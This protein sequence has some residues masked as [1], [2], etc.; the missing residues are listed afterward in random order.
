MALADFDA[1]QTALSEQQSVDFTMTA[2]AML[3]T[4]MAW[5]SR[6]FSPAPA[7]PTTS[8]ALDKTSAHSMAPIPATDGGRLTVLGARFNPNGAGG[9]AVVVVDLLNISGGLSGTVTT[10]QTTNLPTA[11]LTRHTTGAGVMAGIVIHTA[12]GATATTCTVNYTDQDGNSAT[13]TAT[14]IGS[15]T[16]NA[17]GR[18]LPLPLA[19]G[20]TGVQAV[21][22][23][24]LAGTTGTAGNFGVCLFRP[25]AIMSVND[26]QGPAVIDAVT[27]GHWAG[28]LAEVHPDA[29]LSI[30]GMANTAQSMVGTLLLGEV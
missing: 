23:V 18:L 15:S 7:T 16:A 10:E 30:I 25:L 9:I 5:P 21:S 22:S 17:I 8:V 27:S 19:A 2:S 11:A 26:Y 14:P 3:N 6:A 20:D 12:L 29:C 13:T 28:Q 4:R 24:T 1:Y